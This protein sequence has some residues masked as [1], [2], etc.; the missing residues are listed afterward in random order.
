MEV[1]SW[2][3]MSASEVK[4]GISRRT[5]K[6]ERASLSYVELAPGAESPLHQHVHEQ[7]DY[8]LEGELEFSSGSHVVVVK[9]GQVVVLPGC[10]PHRVRNVGA[11]VARNLGVFSPPGV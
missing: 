7:I 10:A 11:G 6:G 5:I 8:V 2:D 9:A 1:H 4:P 3:S